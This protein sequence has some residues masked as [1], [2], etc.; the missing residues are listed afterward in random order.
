MGTHKKKTPSSLSAAAK[1]LGRA[2]GLKGGDARARA[3]SSEERSAIASKAAK[4]RW[5]NAERSQ[6]KPSQKTRNSG[7][8]IKKK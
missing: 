1:A 3:L 4:A 2:G 8:N 6:D 5:K 7:K